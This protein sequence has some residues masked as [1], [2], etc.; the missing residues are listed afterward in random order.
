M[1]SRACFQS[2]FLLAALLLGAPALRAQA[3]ARQGTAADLPFNELKSPLVVEL[4]FEAFEGMKDGDTK[5]FTD[6]AKYVCDDV[7][8]DKIKVKKKV[9]DGGSLVRLVITIDIT[10]RPSYDRAVDLRFVLMKGQ[11]PL[12][13][14]DLR[15]FRTPEDRTRMAEVKLDIA[16]DTF[17]RAFEGPEKPILKVVL[18]VSANR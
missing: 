11:L 1:T 7:M 12:A 3:V 17:R 15:Q 18:A 4:P 14:Q 5:T 13:T 8:L 16:M 2:T 9:K 10:V 6:Q